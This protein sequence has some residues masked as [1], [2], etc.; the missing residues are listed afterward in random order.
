[1]LGLPSEC[2]T[3]L[4]PARCAVRSLQALQC[5]QAALERNRESKQLTE[6]VRLL[7]KIVAK[8]HQQAAASTA[9]AGLH[10]PTEAK[11]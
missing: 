1:M 9:A 3:C 4:T 11:R 2:N 8:Q 10:P 5:Y 6:K 7:Q